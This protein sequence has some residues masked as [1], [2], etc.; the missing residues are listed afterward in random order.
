MKTFASEISTFKGPSFSFYNR[1]ARLLW[2]SVQATLFRFSPRPFHSWRNFLLRLFGASVGRG[3]HIYP[4]VNIWAPWNLKIGDEAGV[5]DRVI[6]YSQGQIS[7]GSRA[8]VSQGAHL[9][10]GTHDYNNPCFPVVTKPITIG[11]NVWIA[12]EVFIHPGVEIGEGAVIGARSV[13]IADM[14][15]WMVCSG[16]PCKPLM[17]RNK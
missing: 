4:K 1:L 5:G 10:A 11:S 12:A 9:C 15:Q 3:A 8:V 14:P 16:F 6:L 17:A 7:I 13:V 2:S